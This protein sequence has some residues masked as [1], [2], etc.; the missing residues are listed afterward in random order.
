MT[1]TAT[2]L[3]ANL[4]A[5]AV[6]MTVSAALSDDTHERSFVAQIGT[7][8]VLVERRVALTNPQIIRGILGTTRASHLD[9]ADVT[10]VVL[11]VQTD[12]P[13]APPAAVAF[14]AGSVPEV[15]A[16]ADAQDVVDALVELGLITQAEA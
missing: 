8:Y 4:S 3:S 5:D 15:P 13:T 10:P 14:V 1:L 16:D 9:G 11:T 7:E 6:E 2:T 12:A